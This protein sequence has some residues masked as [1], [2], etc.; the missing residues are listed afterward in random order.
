MRRNGGQNR[1]GGER[2]IQWR[3]LAL[4]DGLG[5][6]VSDPLVQ[7]HVERSAE[8]L[9]LRR[10]CGLVDRCKQRQ[11]RLGQPVFLNDQDLQARQR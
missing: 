2:G 7:P 8:R 11:V 5:Q 1:V 3:N 4:G 6:E 10:R 9:A